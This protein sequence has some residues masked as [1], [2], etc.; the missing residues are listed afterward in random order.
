M[1][2]LVNGKKV[3]G[4]GPAGLSPYQVAKAGGYAGTEQAF[5][6]QLAGLDTIK[7]KAVAVTLPAASWD[8]AA[9]TQTVSVAGVLADETKQAI[10][11]TP[12]PASWEA[13]GLAGVRCSA[14]AVG[15][16]TFVC[17]T[18]PTVDLTYHVLIQEV[19]G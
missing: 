10:T 14:Q 5:N 1:S 19:Q 4:T 2:I 16:L 13:A 8:T 18:V 17:S 12:T 11:P 3:A 6:A 15:K 9:K 7:P